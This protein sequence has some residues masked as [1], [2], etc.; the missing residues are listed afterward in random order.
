MPVT[1]APSSY[2]TAVNGLTPAYR[3]SLS[4]VKTQASTTEVFAGDTIR[5]SYYHYPIIYVDSS[6][7]YTGKRVSI[8]GAAGAAGTSVTIDDAIAAMEQITLTGY[9]IDNVE[10]S[11]VLCGRAVNN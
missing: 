5:Y 6:Y 3:M 8:R 7:V 11:W 1:T 9:D 2:T 4:T 10:Y